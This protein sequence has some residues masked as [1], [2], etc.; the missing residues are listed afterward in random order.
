M[1]YYPIFLDLKDQRCTVIGGGAVAERKI[2][3]LVQAGARVTV[4][5][6]ELTANLAEWS[7]QQRINAVRRSYRAGDLAECEIVFVAT[8]DSQEN[9]AV[10]AEGKD[11]G[12][13]VN[14]ADDPA[15]CDFIL[16]SVLQ[17]GALTVAVSTGAT[18]PALARLVREELESYFSHD[19]AVVA[20][21]AGEVREELRARG[22]A[23]EY[24]QWRRALTGELRQWVARGERRRAKNFLLKELGAIPCE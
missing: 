9:A 15:H 11:R 16:P 5:A 8:D 3:A 1:G 2:A 23:P 12:V 17:R 18:S 13:W 6:A 20:E 4:I 7:Q 22:I 21:L 19:Y 14:V 24:E 10:R